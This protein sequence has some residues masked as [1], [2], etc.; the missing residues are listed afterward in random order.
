M[1]ENKNT[2]T[3]CKIVVLH[4]DNFFDLLW[5]GHGVE[6]YSYMDS[7]LHLLPNLEK[8]IQSIKWAAS[9]NNQNKRRNK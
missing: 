7:L 4:N 5:Q 9:R 2:N 3:K 8:I 6:K 1:K